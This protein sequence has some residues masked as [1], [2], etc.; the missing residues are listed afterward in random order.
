V[1]T[2]CRQASYPEGAD[3]QVFS[4]ADLADVATRIDDAAVREHVSLY[5]YENPDLYRVI[6]LAAPESVAMPGQRLQLDYAEDLALIR[7]VYGELEP[8]FGTSFTLRDIVALLRRRPDFAAL[9][10]SCEERAVR[11]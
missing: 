6:H 1:V 9:N 7:A 3:V 8:K 10:A 5:F 4:F 2:N 11:A